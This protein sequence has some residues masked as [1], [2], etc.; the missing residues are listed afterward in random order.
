VL[1]SACL[2]GKACRFDGQDR[3]HPDLIEALGDEAVAFCPEEAGGLGTPRPPARIEGDGGEAVLDGLARVLSE[4]GVD[5]TEAYLEGARRAVVLAERE[6]CEAAYLKE[7]SPSCGCARVHT[8]EGLLPGCGVATAM[9][10]RA[11]IATI[12]V[13]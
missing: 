12:S 3:R 4:V 10:R 7:S 8:S 1:V 5:V 11:G 2:L 9:L 13:D 6:G